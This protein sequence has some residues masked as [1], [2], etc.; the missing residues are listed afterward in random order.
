MAANRSFW[1]LIAVAALL[2]LPLAVGHG[3]FTGTDD[4]ASLV[5]E[6]SRPG[7]TPWFAPIWKPPSAEIESLLFALQAA[8]GAGVIGYA[9][10]RKHGQAKLRGDTPHSSTSPAE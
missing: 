10:G 5:I 7:Y 8:L 1:L 2:I 9:I 4:Q 3:T 6:A